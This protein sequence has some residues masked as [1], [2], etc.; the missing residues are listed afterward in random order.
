MKFLFEKADASHNGALVCFVLT[1]V[2][3]SSCLIGF[4]DSKIPHLSAGSQ[5]IGCLSPDTEGRY[6]KMG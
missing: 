3:S 2:V 5:G 6:G 4:L 1:A